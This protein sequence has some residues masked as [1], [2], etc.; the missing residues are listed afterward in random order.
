MEI[1]YCLTCIYKDNSKHLEGNY[2]HFKMPNND[3]LFIA[4]HA[5]LP[6]K[7]AL[8]LWAIH[9]CLIS[10]YFR[11]ARTRDWEKV[12]KTEGWLLFHLKA[13][14]PYWQQ[15]EARLERHIKL[16]QMA[17]LRPQHVSLRYAHQCS[18]TVTPDRITHLSSAHVPLL[19]PSPA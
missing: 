12:T 18:V 3:T 1:K 5:F 13:N 10:D 16:S 2:V 14:I 11:A 9:V 19:P 15:T 6:T 4:L 17:S 7:Q 8:P